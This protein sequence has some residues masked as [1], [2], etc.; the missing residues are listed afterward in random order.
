MRIED[1]KLEF[2]NDEKIMMDFTIEPTKELIKTLNDIRYKEGF[3]QLVQDCD[4]D[5][6][7][8]FYV[9]QNAENTTL[10]LFGKAIDSVDNGEYYIIDLTEN[11]HEELIWK[12]IEKYKEF[13]NKKQIEYWNSETLDVNVVERR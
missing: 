10:K 7:Y 1:F 6:R 11:E 8:E 3:R 5:I 9:Q 12:V 13:Y 4:D 2:C